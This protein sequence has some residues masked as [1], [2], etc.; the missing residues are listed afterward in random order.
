[1]IRHESFSATQKTILREPLDQ[2]REEWSQF[3]CKESVWSKFKN[4]V[5]KLALSPFSPEIDKAELLKKFSMPK[6][7]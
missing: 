7:N 5:E 2:K 4:P 1:M 6:F 3:L